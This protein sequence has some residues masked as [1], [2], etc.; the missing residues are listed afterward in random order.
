[1][2]EL[3]LL[4]LLLVGGGLVLSLVFTLL[5]VVFKLILLPFHV[6]FWLLRGVLGFAL[7]LVGLILLL[8][9]LGVALPALILVF[10]LPLAVIGLIVWLVKR[11]TVHS[12]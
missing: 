2:F 3:G 6:A 12:A 5:G 11:S 8:P 7:G 10:G 1:M 4:L 9:V